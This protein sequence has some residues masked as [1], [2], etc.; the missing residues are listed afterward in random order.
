MG[1]LSVSIA[2][3]GFGGFLAGVVMAGCDCASVAAWSTGDTSLSLE[4]EAKAFSPRREKEEEEKE[5]GAGADPRM[6]PLALALT[7]PA[8]PSAV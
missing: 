5:E 1:F 4:V 2:A 7:C 8:W 3:T 6:A